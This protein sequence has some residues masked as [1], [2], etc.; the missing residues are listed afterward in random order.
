VIIRDT[1]STASP[2]PS[3]A[4]HESAASYLAKYHEETAIKVREAW[5]SFFFNC[6]GRFRDLY[7]V[8]DPHTENF[9][10]SYAYLGAPR[11][12]F[13]QIG[14]WGAPGTPP[15][16]EVSPVGMLPIN[17]PGEVSP[18]AYKSKYPMGFSAPYLWSDTTASAHASHAAGMS[19]PFIV[20]IFIVGVAMGV[21]ATMLLIKKR[22]GPSSYLP[23]N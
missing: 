21:G 7:E 22:G 1:T 14:F 9:I 2:G 5:W 19:L 4:G 10:D 18:A 15:A 12:W 23:I 3:S 17:V 11:W 13:E 16:D 6:A 8:V 20:G